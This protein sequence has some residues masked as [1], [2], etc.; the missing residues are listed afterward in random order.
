MNQQLTLPGYWRMQLH[1]GGST[2][3]TRLACESLAA[4]FIGLD[5]GEPIGDLLVQE[6]ENLPENHKHYWHFAHT[7]AVG[8]RVLIM[9]HNL[10][11]ALCQVADEYNYIRRPE[12]ELGVWFRHFRRVRNVSYFADVFP[13]S[14]DWKGMV[15]TGTINPLKN[16]DTQSR[17]LIAEWIAAISG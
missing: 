2:D 15:M 10:P 7:M 14:D 13:N 12:P 5:F 16:P 6:K 3:R 1:P 17:Q 4:G 8:D 11:L 9:S